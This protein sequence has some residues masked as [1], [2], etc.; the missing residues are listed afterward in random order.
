M[1]TPHGVVGYV[2]DV[3]VDYSQRGSGVGFMLMTE[4]EALA[5]ELGMNELNLTT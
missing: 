1:V 3:V 4:I 5:R 2:H